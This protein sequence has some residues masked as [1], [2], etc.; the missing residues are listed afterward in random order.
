MLRM[1][2]AGS[3]QTRSYLSS[4]YY[5]GRVFFDSVNSNF[6]LQM[7]SNDSSLNEHKVLFWPG[8]AAVLG[9]AS[10]FCTP[11]TPLSNVQ[12]PIYVTQIFL[13]TFVVFSIVLQ[14]LVPG[15]NRPWHVFLLYPSF[16]LLLG[17]A[18]SVIDVWSESHCLL[19]WGKRIAL[20][21]VLAIQLSFLVQTLVRLPNSFGINIH[22]SSVKDAADFLAN[23]KP[24]HLVALNYS[25]SDPLY[26]LSDGAVRVKENYTGP[27]SNKTLEFLKNDHTIS[28]IVYRTPVHAAQVDQNYYEFLLGNS[29][30]VDQL[31]NYTPVAVFTDQSRTSITILQNE[32]VSP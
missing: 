23:I 26:V 14:S 18:I 22:A 4:L 21:G 3:E 2:Y 12:S 32:H 5:L 9:V 11:K 6:F 27:R 1:A 28:H 25:L 8:V 29:Q 24:N 31:S 10:L 7:M 19:L 17:R 20:L 30:L 15:L 16:L 13:A